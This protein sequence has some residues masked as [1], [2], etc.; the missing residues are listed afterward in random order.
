MDRKWCLHVTV[1]CARLFFAKIFVYLI[2]L[3]KKW[4]LLLSFLRKGPFMYETAWHIHCRYT[5]YKTE[6]KRAE[7]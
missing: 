7:K 5:L 1:L 3:V 2:S 6:I 4:R